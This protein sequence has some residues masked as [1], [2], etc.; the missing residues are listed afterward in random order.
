MGGDH[1]PE[2]IRLMCAQHNR[3]MAEQDYGREA[4]ARFNRPAKR[5]DAT[6]VVASFETTAG[7]LRPASPGS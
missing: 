1:R 4:M 7:P 3:Y 6:V 2:N 5:V